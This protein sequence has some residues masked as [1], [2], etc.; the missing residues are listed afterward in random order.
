MLSNWAVIFVR[1][2]CTSWK[3]QIGKAP[4]VRVGPIPPQSLRIGSFQK[5]EG[6]RK[7]LRQACWGM[8]LSSGDLRERLASRRLRIYL[9]QTDGGVS[10][11]GRMETGASEGLPIFGEEECLKER[12]WW[13]FLLSSIFTFLLGI[14]SVLLVRLLQAA[15][16]K[17]VCFLSCSYH[18]LGFLITYCFLRP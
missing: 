6:L 9:F 18:F 5:D 14:F 7:E 17:E 3:A 12:K 4:G 10:K 15:F 1:G 8:C 2:C 13:C 11:Q 16:C